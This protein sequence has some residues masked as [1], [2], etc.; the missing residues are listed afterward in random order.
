MASPV[1]ETRAAFRA[2]GSADTFGYVNVA[3]A[4][5]NYTIAT[6]TRGLY[7]VVW[8][9]SGGVVIVRTDGSAPALPSTGQVGTG[10]IAGAGVAPVIEITTDLQTVQVR[11]PANTG[12]VFFQKIAGY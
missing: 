2:S 6:L 7:Q 5:T 8:D 9:S 12:S 3:A 1:D 10:V 4:A 11:S